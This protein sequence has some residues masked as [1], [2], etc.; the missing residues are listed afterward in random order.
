MP[1]FDSVRGFS[2]EGTF[3]G[4]QPPC[5]KPNS[6]SRDFCLYDE[7][8]LALFHGAEVDEACRMN[9]KDGNGESIRC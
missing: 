1:S 3:N 4:Q 9:S 5:S 6:A 8:P 2:E 7:D